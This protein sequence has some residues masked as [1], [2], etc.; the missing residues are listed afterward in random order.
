[1]KNLIY[2]L[3]ILILTVSCDDNSLTDLNVDEKN[4]TVVPASTLFTN[5]EKDLTEQLI[6][7]DVNKNIFRLLN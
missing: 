2:V 7:T 1:M 4:P 5:A 3:G 6:N